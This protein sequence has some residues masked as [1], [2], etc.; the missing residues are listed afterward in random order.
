[1]IRFKRVRCFIRSNLESVGI[2]EASS[3]CSINV[4]G[5]GAFG[6]VS[7]DCM[8]TYCNCALILLW[9]CTYYK[10]LNVSSQ[11]IY[12]LPFVLS[13]S[14]PPSLI[15]VRLCSKYAFYV[16]KNKSYSRSTC[17]L[18]VHCPQHA[19]WNFAHVPIPRQHSGLRKTADWL[20]GGSDRA[21]NIHCCTQTYLSEAFRRTQWYRVL[22]KCQ[23]FFHLF[24]SVESSLCVTYG[25]KK[26][27]MQDVWQDVWL[28]PDR[29]H[30]QWRNTEKVYKNTLNWMKLFFGTVFMVS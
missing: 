14:L 15:F 6:P 3:Q 19:A 16:E 27:K 5:E 7:D 10:C 28:G 13:L 30:F 24:P 25:G 12:I 23:L 8:V 29:C 11:L 9:L 2:Q 17:T 1:M 21:I 22:R 20:P 4:C 26:I 18:I